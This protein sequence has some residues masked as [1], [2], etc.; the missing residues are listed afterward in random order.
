[1][2]EKQE[3][4]QRK[5]A[6][7]LWL[8]GIRPTQIL[9]IV[10]RSWAWWAKW[11]ERYHHLGWKG[12]RSQSRK[13]QRNP[14]A[15]APPIRRLIVRVYQK[16]QKRCWGLRGLSA[17]RHEL[18]V[19]YRLRPTPS[20]STIRRVLSAAEVFKNRH[21]SRREVYYPQPQPTPTYTIQALDWTERFL[22]GG[23]KVYVFQT[24]DLETRAAT[25]TIAPDKTTSTTFTHLKKVWQ[26]RGI[27]QGLQLDNDTAFYGSRRVPR[28]VSRMMRVCLY[29]GIEPIFIPV[30]EAKR[31]GDVEQLH[32]VWDKAVW[33]RIDFATLPAAQRFTPQFEHWYMTE[34]EPPSLNGR[35]PQEMECGRHRLRL[36]EKQWQTI[37]AEL[38]IT[39]GR[40][41]FI[42]RVSDTGT[43]E[44]LN[45]HWPVSKRLAG[46][47]VW[48]VLWTHRRLLEV[49]HRRSAEA[50]F[51]R[52]K[53]FCYPFAEAVEPLRSEFK[54]RTYRRKSFTMS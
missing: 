33:Q 39:A 7:R 31:N 13:P 25:Q 23:E 22:S 48:A 28:L 53:T 10:N 8:K 26:T 32:G 44:V 46:Q 4:R 45:E 40:I 2:N 54:Q 17:V 29:V 27:P 24:I 42:R 49:F 30:G 50:P 9:G 51:K 21:R 41:H 36:T 43:I 18:R 19:T 12:L 35:T 5:K 38:P 16:I 47:Y 15:Y 1:M 3:E 20:L 37:P 11:K 6:I 52:L 14:Q 34:Y